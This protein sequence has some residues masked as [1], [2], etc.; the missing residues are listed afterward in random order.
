MWVVGVLSGVWGIRCGWCSQVWVVSGCSQVWGVALPC[1]Q[2]RVVGQ[3]CN[4]VWVVG[5]GGSGPSYVMPAALEA[6]QSELFELK[7]KYDEDAVAK[8]ALVCTS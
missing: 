5:N 2:V 4:Q 8:Y 3:T 6:T 1:N 7:N